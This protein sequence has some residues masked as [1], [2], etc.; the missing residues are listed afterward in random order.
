VLRPV[1]QHNSAGDCWVILYD[2]V[3][4][5][6]SFLA[7]HPGGSRIILQLAG[8]DATEQYDPVH[9]KGTLESSMPPV[10]RIGAF[11][12]ATAPKVEKGKGREQEAEEAMPTLDDCMNMDDM[13]ALAT[14]KISKKAWAYYYS[15]GDDLIS[16]ALN[17]EV[18][19]KILLRPRVFVDVV[20]C[21]TSTKM[22]GLPVSLPIFV[23][24]AAQARLAH[25]SGEHGIAQ[26]C[27]KWGA[28]QIISNNASQAPE[29]ICA[30]ALPGQ[31][32]GWQLYVQVDRQKSVAMLARIA[33]IPSIKFIVLTLDAPVPGKRELDEKEGKTLELG[34]Q[35]R[36]QSS[37][38]AKTLSLGLQTRQKSQEEW[39][40]LCLQEL[41]RI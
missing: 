8:S 27:A 17:S 36:V 21:D 34:S 40:K 28:C 12:K 38:R 35:L 4:D 2:Q 24:P 18:Y 16:K 30:N 13:E 7:H 6:S 31:F 11:D 29:E 10:E 26:A 3:Y 22:L 23:S 1:Q 19:R 9:P 14:R 37:R 20:K 32:F 15:A 41:Q 39:G 5:V 33:K 25:D